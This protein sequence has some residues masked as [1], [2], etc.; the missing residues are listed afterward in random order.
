MN[1]R[2]F[3]RNGLAGTA[4]VAITP[5]AFLASC[6]PS[7]PDILNDLLFGEVNGLNVPAP[8]FTNVFANLPTESANGATL[9]ASKNFSIFLGTT[10]TYC[11]GYTDSIWGPTLTA[12][13]GESISL[14]LEAEMAKDTNLHFH[15]LTLDAGEDDA[16]QNVVSD[17]STKNY[18]FT[19]NNRAGMYW[20]HPQIKKLTGEQIGSG[21]GG[22]L[23]VSD[24][25]EDSLNLPQGNL[26]ST[27]LTIQDKRF[28]EDNQ[29]FYSPNI[30]EKLTGYFGETILVNGVNGPVKDIS[31]RIHRLRIINGS[32]ARIYNL[33]MT[34]V[35][36][37]EL[38]FNIIGN[39]GGLL[40]NLG[41]GINLVILAPGERLDALIDFTGLT[42]GTEIMLGSKQFSGGGDYQGKAGFDIL[43]FVISSDETETWS[44]PDDL[45]DITSLTEG[46]VTGETR[47]FDVSNPNI[48]K[49]EATNNTD[50]MHG[51]NGDTYEAGVVN[52][53]VN[54]GAVEKWIFD[55]T[56]GKE[57]RV[58][59]IYGVQGQMYSREGGR[60]SVKQWERGW[61]DTICL[62]P[63][64]KVTMLIPFNVAPGLY[65]IISTN[66]EHA[67]T[68]LMHTFEIV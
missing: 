66:Q 11:Y 27:T 7:N 30:A 54:A 42:V 58:M 25:E 21:I 35:G 1:R 64:E 44:L 19:I 43:K 60:A 39:D 29:M 12:D 47:T 20:Y 10:G 2:S 46:D 16:L 37:A 41:G 63:D 15:G 49:D 34:V 65:H 23:I 6:D 33:S 9:K 62:L 4:A 68:G 17:G 13:S 50:T 61:K 24:S 5:A 18:S 14:T 56:G 3:V 36:G 28:N 22:L 38:P 53:N 45:S 8:P 32:T 40:K 57:P 59:H 67:D 55:N 26:R 52:F 31:N 48:S 51:I